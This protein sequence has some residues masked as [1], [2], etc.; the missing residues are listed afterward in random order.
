MN[1][2]Y[3]PDADP[4]TIPAAIYLD[5]N[6][7]THCTR[8]M[9]A[10]IGDS[11]YLTNGK[12]CLFEGSVQS[13]DP[14]KCS[15]WITSANCQ[16]EKGWKVTIAI[17]PPKNMD[18][19]EWF[20][21]KATEIGIDEIIP[22]YCQHSERTKMRL[23]RL[24]KILVSAMKQS[25]NLFLPV[26]QEPMDFETFIRIPF[27]GQKFIAYVN[28]SQDRLLKNEYTQGQHATILIGPEGDFSENE[29]KMASQQHYQPVSL[30]KSILRTETAAIVACHTLNLLNM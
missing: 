27:E 25:K 28:E 4:L 1:I 17:A 7:S 20:V 19:F 2:Y 23:D 18:R 12:G 22:V 21:E 24:N 10:R 13:V 9:R 15:I 26:I 16:E 11:V 5:S 29:L 3:A 6:E 8:V 30:G 14:Q